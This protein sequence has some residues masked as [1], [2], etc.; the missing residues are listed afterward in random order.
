MTAPNPAWVRTV[1][2][3][4]E[5]AMART[6]RNDS[7]T[8]SLLMRRKLSSSRSSARKALTV[9]MPWNICERAWIEEPSFPRLV[10]ERLRTRL[11]RSA[12]GRTT[13]GSPTSMPRV[14]T[15][16]MRKAIDREAM[17]VKG[18]RIRLRKASLSTPSV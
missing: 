3:E 13:R 10:A 6:M 15:G 5:R 8:Y 9:R 4:F 16:A 14:A 18:S 2:Q 11:P 12:T 1:V 17:A 7:R